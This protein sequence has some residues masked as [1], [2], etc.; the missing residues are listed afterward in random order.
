[1]TPGTQAIIAFD[2]EAVVKTVVVIPPG[3]VKR[4]RAAAREYLLDL[5]RE[6]KP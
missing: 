3:L 4:N 1:M 6:A 5:F 2:V